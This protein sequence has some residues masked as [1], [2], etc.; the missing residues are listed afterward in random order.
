MRSFD[1][2]CGMKGSFVELMAVVESGTKE[3]FCGQKTTG[4][5]A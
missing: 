3:S 1:V 4:L 2:E 5:G